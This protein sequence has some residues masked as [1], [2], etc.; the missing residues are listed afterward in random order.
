MII[1]TEERTV[2]IRDNHKRTTLQF[3]VNKHCINYP[4]R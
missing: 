1:N 4:A 3:D 2:S